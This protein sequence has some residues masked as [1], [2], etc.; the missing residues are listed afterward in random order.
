MYIGL[1]RKYVQHCF[2]CR[3]KNIIIIISSPSLIIRHFYLIIYVVLMG[4]K[5]FKFKWETPPQ[6][7]LLQDL[8]L[9]SFLPP[10]LPSFLPPTIPLWLSH[11]I[12]S[13]LVAKPNSYVNEK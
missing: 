11:P 10:T 6:V 12:P 2:I 8:L 9:I 3:S 5:V 4:I 7:I 13:H 1:F